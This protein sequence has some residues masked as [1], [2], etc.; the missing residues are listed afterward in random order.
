MVNNGILEFIS[1]ELN[2]LFPDWFNK[3]RKRYKDSF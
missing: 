1:Q 3:K 2:L